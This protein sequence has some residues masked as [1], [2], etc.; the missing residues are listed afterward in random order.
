M[1]T[2]EN[3]ILNRFDLDHIDLIQVE[4]MNP[5]FI[6]CRAYFVE[7]NRKVAEQLKLIMEDTDVTVKNLL[8]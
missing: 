4:P 8:E 2:A 3:T 7:G 5:A 1:P 6:K